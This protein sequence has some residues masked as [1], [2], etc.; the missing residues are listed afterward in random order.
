MIKWIISYL[1][2]ITKHIHSTYNGV[3][4]VTWVDGKKVLNTK[5]AN[6]SFGALHKVMRF[7]L[8]KIDLK[9]KDTVLLLGLGGGSVINILRQ[10]LRQNNSIDAIEI[11][12]VIIEV[13]RN[14]FGLGSYSSVNVT[15]I[16]AYKYVERDTK[17]YDLVIID[18]FIDNNIPLKFCENKF[19]KNIYRITDFN[20]SIIFNVLIKTNLKDKIDNIIEGLK[21]SKFN[22]SIYNEVEIENLII[23]AQ[24]QE[25]S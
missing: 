11:D 13:A 2:P 17:L 14:E 20:G 7:A 6:Y 4:E 18:L 3:L 23:I 8:K 21:E 1:Y 16:D 10:E 25:M 22:V 19:W 24:R 9:E 12:P 15:C 5:N